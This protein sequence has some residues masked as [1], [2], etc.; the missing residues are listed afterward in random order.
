[1]TALDIRT[2][3]NNELAGFT[4]DMLLLVDNYVK[5]LRRESRALNRQPESQASDLVPPY[6]KEELCTRIAISE[7]QFAN[8]EWMDFDDAMDEIDR[9]L[10]KELELAEA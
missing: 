4:P 2:S 5:S 1:M 10:D 9:A 8:G 3:I 6:T 7:R